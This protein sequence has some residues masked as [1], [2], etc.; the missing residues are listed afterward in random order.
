MLD[1]LL[2]L[3]RSGSGGGRR[4]LCL[5]VSDLFVDGV[6]RY[7]DRE[8]VLFGEVIGD[9]LG[10]IGADDRAAVARRVAP[11]DR[12]PRELALSLAEDEALPVSAPVLQHSPVLT[13]ED[14]VGLAERKGDAHR[15]AIARRETLAEPVTAALVAHGSDDVLETVTLNRGARFSGRSTAVL[16]ERAAGQERLAA[17]LATRADLPPDVA[18]RVWRI[19]TPAARRAAAELGS[20]VRLVE[21]VVSAAAKGM[22]VARLETHRQRAEARTMV[23]DVQAG[24]RPIDDAL[25]RLVSERRLLDIAY[26]LSELAEVPE[27]HVANALQKPNATA[28]AVVCRHLEVAGAVYAALTRLRCERLCLGEPQI[29]AMLREYRDMTP[30]MADRA[31]KF[32]QKRSASRFARM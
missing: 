28:I 12:T 29:D 16:A 31:L 11:L 30:G 27:A 10:R 4:E 1:R 23:S 8:V 18:D 5:A 6:D 15:L 21:G 13:D 26:L 17:A 14:L 2:D 24:R 25:A 3:A 22:G 7:T 9:L 20:R 19:L 32:H